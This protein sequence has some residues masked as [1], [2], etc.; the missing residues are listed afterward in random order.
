LSSEFAPVSGSDEMLFGMT[1]LPD[2]IRV[3][4]LPGGTFAVD[5]VIPHFH[6]RM[7]VSKRVT[8]EFIARSKFMKMKT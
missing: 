3:E 8:L 2:D 7:V 6:K 1:I 4:D 5:F